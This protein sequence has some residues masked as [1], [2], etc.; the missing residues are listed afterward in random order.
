MNKTT[1]SDPNEVCMPF[2]QI[3]HFLLKTIRDL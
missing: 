3:N 1:V 2:F